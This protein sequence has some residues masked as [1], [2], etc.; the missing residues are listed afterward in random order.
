MEC[1]QCSVDVCVISIVYVTPGI[2]SFRIKLNVPTSPPTL[3]SS[4]LLPAKMSRHER[5]VKVCQK[6]IAPQVTHPNLQRAAAISFLKEEPIKAKEEWSVS[7]SVALFIFL[8]LVCKH[9][10]LRLLLFNFS[11]F[12]PL[13]RNIFDL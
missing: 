12:Y 2:C 1:V 9:F 10:N 5:R 7:A 4:S 8:F 6:E 3:H 13:F 11:I